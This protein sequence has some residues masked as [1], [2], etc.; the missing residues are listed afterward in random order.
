MWTYIYSNELYHYGVLGMKWGVR[1]YQNYDGSYTKKGVSR[2]NKARQ[3]YDDSKSRRKAAKEAY[4]QG[5]SSKEQYKR[6]MKT[7]RADIKKA[8]RDMN[9]AYGKLKTDKMADEGK[10][11][12]QQGKTIGG[13]Y[14]K[15]YVTQAAVIAG[16][17]IVNRILLGTLN[18]VKVANIASTSIALGGTA[19]NAYIAQKTYTDNKK[20]RAYYAHS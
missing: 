8:K 9:K 14:T 2:Y 4:K 7:T 6:D 17:S 3:D 1:R 15:N 13:N 11:L 19:L 20:L 16:S 10:K 12:Y 18:N 5:I